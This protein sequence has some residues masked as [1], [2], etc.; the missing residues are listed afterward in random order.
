MS[1]YRKHLAHAAHEFIYYWVL[2]QRAEISEFSSV[3]QSPPVAT[4]LFGASRI[5]FSVSLLSLFPPPGAVSFCMLLESWILL[6]GDQYKLCIAFFQGCTS[7]NLYSE[8]TDARRRV[9]R[10]LQNELPA[11]MIIW[12]PPRS[13]LPNA[14]IIWVHHLTLLTALIFLIAWRTDIPDLHREICKDSRQP[15]PRCTQWTQWASA[16]EHYLAYRVCAHINRE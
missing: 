16:A 2:R 3:A 13:A 15:W 14:W 4:K 12:W 8:L 6:A 1:A 11:P 9:H 5:L 7:S 10:V